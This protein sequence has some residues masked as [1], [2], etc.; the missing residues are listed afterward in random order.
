MVQNML[1]HLKCVLVEYKMLIIKMSQDNIVIAQA[2]L[3]LDLFW[4]VKTLLT[5]FYVLPLLEVVNFLIKFAQGRDF[6]ILDLKAIVKICLV[7]LFMK[8]INLM[9]NYH[10]ENFQVFYDV[11]ENI[12][13][14]INQDWVIDSYI[15]T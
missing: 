4:D 10:H 6:F 15:S 14:T 13:A 12:F 3:N 1:E 8:Y 9:N 5:L 11:V 7:D 2:R